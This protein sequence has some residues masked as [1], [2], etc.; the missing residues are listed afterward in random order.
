MTSR[1]A[2]VAIDGTNNIVLTD[3]LG[4]VITTVTD[5]SRWV[6]NLIH[7]KI[8]QEVN[9]A[10]IEAAKLTGDTLEPSLGRQGVWL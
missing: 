8:M 10:M 5:V 7:M 9:E 6:D 4:N 3:E 2:R 1:L